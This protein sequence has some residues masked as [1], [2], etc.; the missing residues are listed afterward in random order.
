[1]RCPQCGSE[2]EWYTALSSKSRTVIC[3]SCNTT[4]Q[5]CGT[6]K[7]VVFPMIAFFFFPF[8]LFPSGSVWLLPV[9]LIAVLGTYYMAFRLFVRLQMVDASATE[10]GK[11]Q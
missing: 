3:D 10:P 2:I 4:L 8:F 11:N 7:F 9:S 6:L 5:V 1:M